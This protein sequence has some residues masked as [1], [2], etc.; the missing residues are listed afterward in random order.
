MVTVPTSGALLAI[1]DLADKIPCAHIASH[2]A[3]HEKP[4]GDCFYRVCRCMTPVTHFVSLMTTPRPSLPLLPRSA[5]AA[6]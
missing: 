5:M 2:P 4:A 3:P 6:V 1:E